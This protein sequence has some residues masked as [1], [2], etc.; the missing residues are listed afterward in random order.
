MPTTPPPQTLLRDLSDIEFLER[1]GTDPFTASVLSN[2]LR[3][4]AQHVATGLL[5]RAFSPIIALA[6][7]YVC[8][9]LGPP[10]QNYRMVTATNGLTV[11]L[12]TLQDGVRVAVEEYGVDRL[13]PG[14]LLICNDPSRVGNHA[15][16]VCF[17]R[18]IFH[19]GRLVGF[20]VLRAHVIDIG[21]ITPGGFDT[22]KKN[23]YETGLIIGPRLLFHNE[24][25]VR[26][27]FT[28][29]F[30]NSRFGEIQLPDYKTIHG[31]CRL[32][33]SLIVESIDRYGV[34]AYLG[35]LEY[36]CDTTAERMRLAIAELPDGDY[37]G[38]AGI[39]A[40]GVDADE[41]YLVRVRIAKRGDRIEADFS[42]SSRQARTAINAGAL[43]A[44]TAVGVGLKVLLDPLGHFT[45][46]SFRNIDIVIPPGTI[47][48]ALPPDGAIFFY[49]EVAN[50]VMTALIDALGNALGD[51]AVGGD[52]GSNNVH[53]AFGVS[54][55]GTPWAAGAVAGAETGP[56][57]ADRHS[58][59]E[60]HVCP[61]LINIISPAT[62]GIEAQFPVMVM[63]KEYAADTA[64]T[65]LHR[66]GAAILKDIQWTGPAQHQVAPFRF[67]KPS[68]L[69]VQGG[70][71]GVQGGLWV[72]GMDGADTG[73]VAE[74][75]SAYAGAT[76]IAGVMNPETNRL[77]PDGE[78]AYYASQRTWS[79]RPGATFRYLT[80]GGG[81]WGEATAR[82]PEAV[83]RDVRDGYVSVEA[84]AAHYGVVVVGD[85]DNDPEGLRVDTD[86][87]A[88]LR[89]GATDKE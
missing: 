69:G 47:A 70:T 29:I 22:N 82:D 89:A 16:D 7:D 33:E 6:M 19:S 2:R 3:A 84:A 66:G 5:H 80:N 38:Q 79:T 45:S 35:T 23:I 1:Y 20:M 50:T 28:M 51:R 53:N 14:D 15:N 59:G 39:D 54:A 64:G 67:R 32:G 78:Y 46:G 48:S 11:F 73:F 17:I 27:T 63:R 24:E 43:D 37:E 81:G 41:E 30:D 36:S 26:E 52:C 40:D 55:D 65:G 9:I 60:G 10:E 72:F 44:K 61:Y 8:A 68:G 21:G 13:A 57:G 25:P 77:D 85:P 71:S 42:G 88:A 74:D 62:E 56:V 49:W 86:A 83:K 87:T 4:A 12:G 76:A 18:P 75:D 31:C 34:D 58:D